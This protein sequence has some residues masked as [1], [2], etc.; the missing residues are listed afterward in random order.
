LA[1]VRDKNLSCLNSKINQTV[2]PF[3]GS[4]TLCAERIKIRRETFAGTF[5]AKH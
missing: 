2:L 1:L 4:S 5:I 3:K